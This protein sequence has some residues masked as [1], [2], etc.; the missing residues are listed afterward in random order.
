V[1]PVIF[2]GLR[3]RQRRARHPDFAAAQRLGGVAV[4]DI[5]EDGDDA[6]GGHAPARARQ[7]AF[8]ALRVAQDPRLVAEDRVGG[9]GERLELQFTAHAERAV[10]PAQQDA[11]RLGFHAGSAA[12]S[13]AGMGQA[14][15][16]AGAAAAALVASLY[17]LR[18]LSLSCAPCPT[19]WSTR[20]VSSSMR[21]SAPE[22][23][24][25]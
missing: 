23:T 4:G 22:A 11:A 16:A 21:F 18:T 3:R 19:Q 12:R 5:G 6:L 14:A 17:R 1:H 25:L 10:D 9:V 20:A 8:A 24:G 2:A 7:L 13:A 15:G